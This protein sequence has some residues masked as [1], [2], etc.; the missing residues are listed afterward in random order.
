[1]VGRAGDAVEKT[2]TAITAEAK[3]GLIPRWIRQMCI[4][5]RVD[6]TGVD[7]SGAVALGT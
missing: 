2:A 5:V 6:K 1:M 4:T 7:P 3:R